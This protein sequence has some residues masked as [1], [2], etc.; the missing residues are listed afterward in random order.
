MHAEKVEKIRLQYTLQSSPSKD[1]KH[2]MDLFLRCLDG[3]WD[4]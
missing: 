2:H 3:S 1:E 4:C